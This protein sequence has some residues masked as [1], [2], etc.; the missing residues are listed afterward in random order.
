MYMVLN[1]SN[2]LKN[3]IIMFVIRVLCIPYMLMP[4]RYLSSHLK[5]RNKCDGFDMTKSLL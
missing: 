5:E 2:S 4:T 1:S 3:Q